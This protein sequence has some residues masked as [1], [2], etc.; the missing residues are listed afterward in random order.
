M[1]KS[2]VLLVGAV[3][4]GM[5]AFSSCDKDDGK[6]EAQKEA[7]VRTETMWDSTN[8]LK[9]TVEGSDVLGSVCYTPDAA[10]ASKASMLIK[11]EMTD[12]SELLQGLVMES[13][14]SRAVLTV[15]TSNVLP[16]SPSL[17]LNVTM[18][19]KN[20][21][22]SFEG[23]SET[24]YCTYSYKG[25]V[26]ESDLS[27]AFDNVLLKNQAFAGT[28]WNL[29]RS[30]EKMKTI[31]ITCPTA[32]PA[33]KTVQIVGLIEMIRPL[34]QIDMEV[35][36]LTL[37]DV[38]CGVLSSISFKE[39]GVWNIAYKTN[40]F[41]NTF[42]VE[43]PNTALKYVLADN[44]SVKLFVNP[45]ELI[46]NGGSPESKMF[47]LGNTRA[48]ESGFDPLSL[49]TIASAAIANDLTEGVK[50]NYVM[51]D[52]M[53]QLTLDPAIVN[54]VMAIVLPLLKTTEVQAEIAEALMEDPEVAPYAQ[55]FGMMLGSLPTELDEDMLITFNFEKLS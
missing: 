28:K 54:R 23:R 11:G 14:E 12:V 24:D 53:L 10:D 48:G 15:A 51:T 2:F 37:D 9:L 29:H 35:A 31:E 6:K 5:M 4:F 36:K 8:G 19:I 44:S 46:R 3:L 25:K 45:G 30:D 42:P 16:G 34:L 39:N 1:K 21:T 18:D 20:E 43:T 7:P 33:S 17:P 55:L 47:L 26:S 22:G 38:L 40:P 52:N 27:I 49:I 13:D 32:G 41:I 50:F